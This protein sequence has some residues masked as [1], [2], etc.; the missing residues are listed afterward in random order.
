MECAL[1]MLFSDECGYCNKNEGHS[2]LDRRNQNQGGGRGL[3]NKIRIIHVMRT[4]FAQHV[5]FE[6]M[7]IK[8]V[9]PLSG[10]VLTLQMTKTLEQP[11]HP[12]EL[13]VKTEMM[14]L[15]SVQTATTDQG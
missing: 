14:K 9:E 7:A 12:S 1:A 11:P 6:A 13:L 3:I 8:V 15:Q 5:N 2:H 4:L 10:L